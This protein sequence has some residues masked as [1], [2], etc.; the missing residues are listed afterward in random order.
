MIPLNDPSARMQLRSMGE[1]VRPAACCVCG[2]GTHEDG[3]LDLG[4]YYDYEGQ[5]YLCKTCATQA[6]ETIGMYTPDEVKNLQD[7][8]ANLLADKERLESELDYAR[9]IVRAFES[10]KPIAASTDSAVSFAPYEVLPESDESSDELVTESVSGE[11]KTEEPDSSVGR[12]DIS[13]AQQ[14]N[15]TFQ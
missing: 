5:M 9:P 15:F 11:P 6:G 12:S 13:G 10:L 7:L 14:H 3:Y 1:L 4:V 2:N 8:A